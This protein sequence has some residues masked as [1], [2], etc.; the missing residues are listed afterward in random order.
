MTDPSFRPIVSPSP[1]DP[2]AD[3]LAAVRDRFR[4]STDGVIETIAADHGLSPR[5]VAGC[6]PAVT[7][8]RVG[9]AHFQVVMD[10]VATWGEVMVL[11]HTPDLI[12]ECRGPLPQGQEGHG[13]FNLMGP[14]PI[15]GHIRH[16][17]CTEIQFVSRPFM[18]AD[19]HAILFFNADGGVMFKIFVGRDASRSL[20]SDQVARFQVLRDRLAAAPVAGVSDAVG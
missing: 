10:D 16:H 2:R 1:D 20:R 18:S 13:F 9:G 3:A 4:I 14:S 19:S 5:E 8:V 15:G 6:L 11:V 7:G 17:R 12:L